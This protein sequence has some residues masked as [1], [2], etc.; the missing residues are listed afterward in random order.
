MSTS[1]IHIKARLVNPKV[2]PNPIPS[3]VQLYFMSAFEFPALEK[4]HLLAEQIDTNQL[5]A[6]TKHRN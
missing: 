2:N 3:P 5:E 4:S 6:T 1:P